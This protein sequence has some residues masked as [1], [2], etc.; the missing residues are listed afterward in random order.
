MP[1]QCCSLRRG[2]AAKMRWGD[3]KKAPPLT[4]SRGMFAASLLVVAVMATY[5]GLAA[6]SLSGGGSYTFLTRL[7]GKVAG[8]LVST[9][10]WQAPPV[11]HYVK[12]QAPSSGQ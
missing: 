4:R 1:I 11:K 8:G 6:I 2:S 12:V 5:A 10:G 3:A 9:V 7:P